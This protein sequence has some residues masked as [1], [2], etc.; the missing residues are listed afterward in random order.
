MDGFFTNRSEMSLRF[1]IDQGFRCNSKIGNPFQG[2]RMVRQLPGSPTR[3]L[4][5]V[6]VLEQLGY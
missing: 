2:G 1:M 6:K 4:D 3:V 5:A